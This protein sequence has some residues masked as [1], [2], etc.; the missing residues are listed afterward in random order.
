MNEIQQIRGKLGDYP[1]AVFSFQGKLHI[2]R[3]S[4]EY[5]QTMQEENFHHLMGIYTKGCP[6]EW[7]AEDLEYMKTCKH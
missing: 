7:I 6:D 3:A 4:S 1:M 5:C 2:L